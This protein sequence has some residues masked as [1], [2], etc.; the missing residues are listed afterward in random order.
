MCR[1]RSLPADQWNVRVTLFGYPVIGQAD[2]EW[3]QPAQDIEHFYDEFGLEG[4]GVPAGTTEQELE[5]D[6]ESAMQTVTMG[7]GTI[8]AEAFLDDAEIERTRREF[9]YGAVAHAWRLTEIFG[10]EAFSLRIITTWTSGPQSRLGLQTPESRTLVFGNDLLSKV[11]DTLT[12][13]LER[14]GSRP[15]EVLLVPD[16]HPSSDK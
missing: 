9:V 3:G 15:V 12:A 1:M 13:E 6:P 4:T 2:S 8:F 7:D 10:A 16:V 14:Q 11:T 5:P